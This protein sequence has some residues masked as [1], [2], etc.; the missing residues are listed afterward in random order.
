MKHYTTTEARKHLSAI[1]N[2]VRYQKI[3]ISIGRR[4]E[5]EVLVIPKWTMDES[6]PISEINAQSQ[7][8][9]FLE[10]EPDLYSLEDLKRR[11]V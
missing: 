7:S 10:D 2:Q 1:V 3:T 9:Q 8:F 4:D 11:Y 5:E 6:L